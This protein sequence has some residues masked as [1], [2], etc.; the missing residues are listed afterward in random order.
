MSV[1]N[2]EAHRIAREKG[3]NKVGYFFVKLFANRDDMRCNPGIAVNIQANGPGIA[4]HRRTFERQP[5]EHLFVG[6][7]SREPGRE[8]RTGDDDE[9]DEEPG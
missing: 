6:I 4:D 9:N 7:V 1:T 2:E 5:V 3:V 8:D